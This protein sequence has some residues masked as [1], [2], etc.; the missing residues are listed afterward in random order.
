VHDHKTWRIEK[1]ESS[2]SLLLVYDSSQQKFLDM[3]VQW[4]GVEVYII[5]GAYC[6]GCKLY[7][8]CVGV[9]GDVPVIPGCCPY[10]VS[11]ALWMA[12]VRLSVGV[13][14]SSVRSRSTYPNVNNYRP[15]SLSKY[16]HCFKWY[17][18]KITETW[19]SRQY[20]FIDRVCCELTIRLLL[21]R[22]P[23]FYDENHAYLDRL[24]LTFDRVY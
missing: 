23:K 24:Y 17:P 8:V 22:V 10:I 19:H 11:F 14:A 2:V 3:I 6:R 13:A 15:T 20:N 21:P 5:F 18:T 7:K 4:I 12:Y 9:N 1:V 16:K